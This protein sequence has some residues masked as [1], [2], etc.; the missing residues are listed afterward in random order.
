MPEDRPFVIVG[1]GLAGAKAAQTLREEGFDGSIVLI[2]E[3]SDRPYERP[4]LSKSLLLRSAEP[5]SVYVHD[6]AWYAD[7]DV[8]LRTATRATAIDRAAHC[9][10]LADGQRVTY[11]KLLLATG[12]TPRTLAVPGAHLDGVLQLRTL[13]DSRR[14]AAALVDG[15]R[16]VIIGAGW[17]GLEV[18]AAARQRGAS[19]AVVEMADLPLQRVLGDEI[20]RVFAE[21]HRDHGVTFHVATQVREVR[22]AGRVSSVLLADGTELPADAVVVGVGVRPNTDLADQAGLPVDNGILVDESLRTGD[23]D[24]YAAGDVANA[25]HPLLARHIR[26]EHWAN[27]L[28]SG[29]A[30]ARAM[31]GQPVSYDQLPY[32]YTDQYDLGMEYTGHAAPGDFDRV[33]IRGD[34]AKREFIA[35]WTAGGRVLAGMN[36]NVWDVVAPIQRLIRSARQVDPVR[37][38]DADT[39]LDELLDDL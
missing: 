6:A 18:A 5:D 23:P 15:A 9:L 2:G 3:E 39:P 21:L 27:A 22:G 17:I 14:I 35:F 8:D 4:P 1:A 25:Y 12:C 28:N 19:V 29:P 11:Q 36:A 34:L 38:A 10:E 20:A 31:L 13:A 16:I 26:V 30:A 24:I 33:V 7:H 32:F 37:L